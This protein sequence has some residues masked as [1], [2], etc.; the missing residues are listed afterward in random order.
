MRK[1]DLIGIST[2]SDPLAVKEVFELAACEAGVVETAEYYG[3]AIPQKAVK[4]SSEDA[5]LWEEEYLHRDETEPTPSSESERVDG[6][7]IENGGAS[8]ESIT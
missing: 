1:Q 2:S 7:L 5:A 8:I 4:K 6:M 3:E